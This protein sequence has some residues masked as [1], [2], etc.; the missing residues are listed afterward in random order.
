MNCRISS[1]VFDANL[2]KINQLDS[3]LHFSGSALARLLDLDPPHPSPLLPHTPPLTPGQ[4]A[5]QGTHTKGRSPQPTATA[6][7]GDS[8]LSHAG[9]LARWLQHHI[10]LDEGRS[11]ARNSVAQ[12][13]R[14]GRCSLRAASA[15]VP[16]WKRHKNICPR[17]TPFDIVSVQNDN[18]REVR[19]DGM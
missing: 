5:R 18:R 9:T 16:V 11:N 8:V 15:L 14:V 1:R 10:V 17:R 2:T 4:T 7:A 19:L 13:R 6:L 12:T 3:W